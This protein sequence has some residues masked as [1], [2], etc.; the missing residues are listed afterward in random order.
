MSTWQWKTLSMQSIKGNKGLLTFNH[1]SQKVNNLLSYIKLHI[2]SNA[3]ANSH[4]QVSQ[5][6]CYS[7]DYL[8]LWTSVLLS[9]MHMQFEKGGQQ[10]HHFH[11]QFEHLALALAPISYILLKFGHGLP[12]E[13][14]TDDEIGSL[15]P[16]PV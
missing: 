9:G 8:V 10:A 4:P 1:Q 2:P 3:G 14:S 11:H 16:Q 13:L 15:Q 5:E 7:Q 12:E 6:I